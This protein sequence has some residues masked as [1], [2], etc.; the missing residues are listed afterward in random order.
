MSPRLPRIS[1]L[2]LG[3]LAA[4][5]AH[6]QN[7][8]QAA[9][10]GATDLDHIVVKGEKT[11]RSLQDTAS[12]VAVTT[13]ARI[14][15]ENL[16]TL[17]DVLNRT[18]NVATMYGNSGY[19]IRGIP[20]ESTLPNPMATTY[21]DGAALPSNA[22]ESAPTDLWD[23]AQVE[24]FRG[25]QS[26]VQGQNALAGAIVMRTEDP[27][28]DWSGRARVLLSNP[29]DYRA[30][31]AGGG[32]LVKDELAFRVAVEKR[33][34]DG[35]VRNTTRNAGEDAVDST[36]ARAKLLWTPKGLDGLT[37]RLTYTRDDREGPYRFSYSRN[38]VPDYYEHRIN[39]SNRADVSD[40]LS[41]VANLQVDYDFAGPWTLS[42]VTSW[43]NSDL[44]R[45]YD[46]D[47]GPEDIEYGHT[48]ED[49]TVASQEFRLHYAGER[50]SSLV[51]VYASNRDRDNSQTLRTNID[52]PVVTIAAALQGFGLDAATAGAIAG[53]YA[54]AQPVIPVDYIGVNGSKS[55][56]RA[57]FADGEFAFGERWSLLAGFRYDRES[58]GFDSVSDAQIAGALPDPA[59]FAPV[60]GALAP[61]VIGGI[62]SYV[63]GV[64]ASASA[65]T[66]WHDDDFTAFLPKLGLRWSWLADK[67]LAFT[68]QRG[69]RSGGSSYNTARGQSFA[70]D[71]EYT[72]NYELALRTQ[73]LDGR[74]TF[75][76]NAYYIDWKDKQVGAYFSPDNS[77]DYHIINAAKAHLYGFEAEVRHRIGADF[78]WYAGLGYSRTRYD[79]FNAQAGASFTDYSGYEFAYAP[80]W[81]F[82]LGGN[83]RWSEG[84]FANANANFR[85]R[86]IVDVGAGDAVLASRVVAN[87]KLGYENL[88]WSAYAFANNLFDRG[89]LQYVWR[90]DPNVILGAPRV[91]GVGFEYR[92]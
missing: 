78:D 19:T 71:P 41:Q 27:T 14:E 67:S 50:L 25:P 10:G 90:D 44:T 28:M 8:D 12:S 39:T 64:A 38:D 32:P 91:V 22:E 46:N 73:W 51:G 24:L 21:L 74:L 62:N 55:K 66:P 88:D 4:M 59:L 6:A 5:H 83:L 18:P 85:D 86:M 61:V 70:Y 58:Y 52:T 34:F 80:R 26:T 56:N 15:Q 60:L 37:A 9:P 49:Y 79:E 53:L 16:Q 89:Y 65:V 48:D 42:S 33:D 72:L 2:S 3:L 11:D 23:I 76:A 75:N 36:T 17:L 82:S 31:F 1:L 30:A 69:Y 68:A 54:A 57:V 35:F 63:Y 20:S 29:A 7:A 81:T 13:S 45:D 84:W 77:Y 40:V 87:L 43:S 47:H 92:W